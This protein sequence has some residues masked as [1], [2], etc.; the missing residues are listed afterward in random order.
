MCSTCAQTVPFRRLGGEGERPHEVRVDK[1]RVRRA[2]NDPIESATAAPQTQIGS[3]LVGELDDGGACRPGIVDRILLLAALLEAEDVIAGHVDDATMALRRGS[4]K[5]GN[6]LR[7]MRSGLPRECSARSTLRMPEPSL[8]SLPNTTQ[9]RS[10]GR[11]MVRFEASNGRATTGSIVGER[12][13]GYGEWRA[14]RTNRIVGAQALRRRL[15]RLGGARVGKSGRALVGSELRQWDG[16]RHL[17]ERAALAQRRA[18][19]HRQAKGDE[20]TKGIDHACKVGR[21][22]K[23]KL[24]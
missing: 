17:D 8:G 20:C 3:V 7:S 21:D 11:E 16:S 13:I 12:R 4:V 1:A 23:L 14:E 15:H 18:L 24:L 5:N 22:S 10:G 2:L 19:R 9:S 6:A